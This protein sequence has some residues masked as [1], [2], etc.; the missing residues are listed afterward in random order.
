M[1]MRDALAS[2]AGKRVFVTGHTGFK[3]AWLTFLLKELGAEVMGF[4][5]PP[6]PGPSHFELLGLRNAIRHVVGDVVDASA[7]SDALQAFQPEY[8]FHLAAQALV[9]GLVDELALFVWP[10]VLGGRTPALPTDMRVDL[11]LIDEH[12]FSSGVVHLHYRLP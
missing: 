1:K 7:L 9:A 11:T 2:F 4:A 12:R 6:E 10:V 3:G 8:V 5:L